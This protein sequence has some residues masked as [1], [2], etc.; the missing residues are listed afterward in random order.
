VCGDTCTGTGESCGGGGQA[1]VCGCTDDGT[2]CGAAICDT[3]IN[4]CGETVRC[5]P[6][7]GACPQVPGQV[8]DK[9]ACVCTPDSCPSGCCQNQVCHIDDDAACGTGGGS[10]DA[11]TGTGERC[12][13]G[14]EAGVCGCT[15]DGSACGT[16]IC[17]TATNNCGD[18][19]N[20]GPLGGACPQEPGQTCAAGAC[21]CT[22]AS[23]PSG[24]CDADGFCQPGTALGAC[25]P[26]GGT[27]Q[28]C[29]GTAACTGGACA[30]TVL[31][32]T[33]NGPRDLSRAS[34]FFDVP[35]VGSSDADELVV[36]LQPANPLPPG[37]TICSDPFVGLVS[38][39][40]LETAVI[41][42]GS[43]QWTGS[44]YGFPGPIMTVGG[45]AV[46]NTSTSSTI[47]NST[48]TVR[49]VTAANSPC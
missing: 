19:V 24:C 17:G 29:P 38:G 3:A 36:T 47:G 49:L 40:E 30:G 37:Q 35:P 18:M 10:C 5:G 34:F 23:C 12:G 6:L 33:N 48:V 20:C 4:N 45:A 21:V 8:C 43:N 44:I 15:D 7:D 1:G 25:G 2:A 27:C 31:V 42:Y 14:G 13:G 11:C 39:S 32:A 9:G 41:R 46:T 16:A 22:A 28:V 26:A